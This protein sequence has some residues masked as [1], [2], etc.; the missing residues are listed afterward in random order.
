MKRENLRK[1]G[2]RM[3]DL[4]AM[5][6]QER[7]VTVLERNFRSREAEIDIIGRQGETLIFAE[8][9][10]RRRGKKSGGGEEAVGA[11][12]QKRICRC[13]D[14]YMHE[15]GINPCETMIRFDVIS[16][17][18]DPQAQPEA[19]SGTAE[20]AR[21]SEESSAEI[22]WIRDAFSYVPYGRSKPHWR[23]W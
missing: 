23:V 2:N 17:S 15:K 19:E 22:R 11:A 6:L 12:K 5:Y 13:A 4:A 14:F 3:E 9:K 8:V 10:A 7:G 21:L 16:I 20:E 18:A 1:T